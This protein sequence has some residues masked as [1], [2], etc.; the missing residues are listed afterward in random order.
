MKFVG[1]EKYFKVIETKPNVPSKY[2]QWIKL[3][4]VEGVRPNGYLLRFPFYLQ[5]AQNAFVVVSTKEN[6]TELDH[7]YELG[8]SSNI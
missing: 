3:D 8:K 6:P 5:G 4:D 2:L 1:F 7:A